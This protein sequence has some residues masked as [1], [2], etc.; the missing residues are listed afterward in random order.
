MEIYNKNSNV[1]INCLYFTHKNFYG[2]TCIIRILSALWIS[3]SLAN[4]FLRDAT[5]FSKCSRWRAYSFWISASTPAC[6]GCRSKKYD[7]MNKEICIILFKK[8]LTADS[9][10]LFWK[11]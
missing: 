11:Q 6:S 8:R 3:V 7:S 9:L 2:I 4:F 1:G 5:L 10:Q